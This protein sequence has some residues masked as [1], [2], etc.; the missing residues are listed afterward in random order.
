MK[1]Y[2]LKIIKYQLA[3]LEVLEYHNLLKEIIENRK[4]SK[5]L[6]AIKENVK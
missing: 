6:K 4:I 5:I 3:I 1:I 2:Q